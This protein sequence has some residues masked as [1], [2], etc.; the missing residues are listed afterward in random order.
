MRRQAVKQV[1]QYQNKEMDLFWK[2]VFIGSVEWG[3]EV[4]GQGE[5]TQ[6]GYLGSQKSQ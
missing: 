3:G 1:E 5:E 6:D 2:V 4:E